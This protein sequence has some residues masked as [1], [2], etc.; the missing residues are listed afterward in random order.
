MAL[1]WLVPRKV[2]DAVGPFRV[3]GLAYDTDYANRLA[4]LNF[5]VVCLKPS[6]VQN[7]GYHGAYQTDD[8]LTARD[9]VGRMGWRLGTSAAVYA[10]RR[11]ALRLAHA[12]Y[13][14]IPECGLKKLVRRVRSG[15]S[16]Q[17]A[18]S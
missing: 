18:G 4:A 10:V 16:L 14:R 11:H 13:D 17:H 12:V 5:P 2:Y 3:T 6:Y 15:K 7:I 1:N 9:F 8:T